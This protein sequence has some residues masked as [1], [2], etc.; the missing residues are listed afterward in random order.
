MHIVVC[1][2]LS[3]YAQYFCMRYL[4]RQASATWF[5]RVLFFQE[6]DSILGDD[7]GKLCVAI[8]ESFAKGEMPMV[9]LC[10]HVFCLCGYVGVHTC[11]STYSTVMFACMCI[12]LSG[13]LFCGTFQERD[14]VWLCVCVCVCEYGSL[15]SAY[16]CRCVYIVCGYV[17]MCSG[18]THT[19]CTHLYVCM[20]I[21]IY[22]YMVFIVY[23][24]I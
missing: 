2:S 21:Y 1:L 7:F 19:I 13:V 22:I 20:Y 18:L 11:I 23:V 16:V 24:C 4:T 5:W 17:C 9:C 14:S 12:N 15:R 8:S 10:M 6:A 3:V